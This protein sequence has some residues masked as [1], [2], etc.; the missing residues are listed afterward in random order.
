M[1]NC[2]Q[3]AELLPLY[4]GRD[5]D[6]ERERLV[7][8][9]LESCAACGSAAVEYRESRQLLQDYVPPVFSEDVFAEIRQNVWRQ[10]ETESTRR[11]SW[12]AITGLFR[13]R[14]AWALA[15]GVLI[16]ALLFGFYLIAHRSTGPQQMPGTYSASKPSLRDPEP[17]APLPAPK[18][19]L[20]PGDSKENPGAERFV[21]N[22]PIHRPHR[23]RLVE[24]NSATVAVSAPSP[25]TDNSS[26]ANSAV[27]FDVRSDLKPENPLRMEIQTKN[28][29]IRIIW[30]SQPDRKRVSTTSKG[31]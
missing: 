26:S 4:A 20:P 16:F 18:V 3:T 31:I 7:T 24:S 11:P 9:H 12:E 10:I 29:N 13:P 2:K 25:K 15:A 8:A 1:M 19:L 17:P 6:A 28:P 22:R 14:P 30:F 21:G 23:N 27:Q 5:L